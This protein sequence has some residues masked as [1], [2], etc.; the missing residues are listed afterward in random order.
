MRWSSPGYDKVSTEKTGLP[1]QKALTLETATIREWLVNSGALIRW[2]ADENMIM[3][4]LTKGH[5]GS[6]TA[7]R[8]MER[9]KRRY[10]VVR[11]KPTT[12]SK[13]TRRTKLEQTSTRSSPAE[14]HH[15]S[16]VSLT[17]W[18]MQGR[19]SRLFKFLL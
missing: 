14:L 6:S 15:E 18:R 19:L 1:K 16:N 12:Q 10:V 11:T 2:T 17:M 7:E 9:T 13:R 4:G 8:R 3:N 5:K